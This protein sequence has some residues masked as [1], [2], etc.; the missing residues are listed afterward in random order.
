MIP[1][2]IMFGDSARQ[3]MLRGIQTLTDAVKVTLGPKGR[4]VVINNRNQP[5]RITKD[6]VSVA[7]EVVLKDD[8]E[9]LGARI[10]KEV[11]I[12]TC[13][14]AGDGT[15]T[16]T[17]LAC[18][19]ITKGMA[20]LEDG[21]NPVALKRGIDL[22]V[23]EVVSFLKSI[24]KEI[25]SHEEIVQVATISANGEE[26]IG[27]LIADA[28][29]KV[30]KDGAVTI[31]ET[32]SIKTELEIVNGLQF[33]SGYISPYFV[34]NAAKMICELDNPYILIYENKFSSF[35]QL[36]NI[37]EYVAQNNQSLL[38]ICDEMELDAL[39][40]FVL[41]KVRR[42]YKIAAVKC[43]GMDQGRFDLLQDLSAMTG[44]HI[45][46]SH[47]GIK[48]QNAK[49]E[50]LGKVTK[51]IITHNST[52][53]IGEESDQENLKL[54]IEYL[55]DE[56]TKSDDDQ[57]V[58]Y[59]RA[60]LGSLT[61]GIAVIRV[62]GSTELEMKERKDRVEDA[63]HATRA[64]LQEGIVPGGGI[65]LYKARLIDFLDSRL[66]DEIY[67]GEQIVHRAIQKPILQILENSG[68]K[69]D[70]FIDS[71]LCYNINT[72][73]QIS[74]GY[75]AKNECFVDMFEAGI[76]DPTKVVRTALEDAAS[77]AGLF[78]LTEVAMLEEM[79]IMVGD[80]DSSP[81]TFRIKTA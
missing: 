5:L 64:A 21:A 48:T 38:V 39:Q 9:N 49:P 32:K 31:E 33:H 4:N 51:A 25:T 16:A 29:A 10:L 71:V 63:M 42:G 80:M 20:A 1:K 72:N 65:A 60:R 19:I 45:F 13:S 22:A 76:I 30:T 69:S 66:E 57:M 2:E 17:V 11:A 15:T 79:E 46:S 47:T 44:A 24:S 41:G 18:E 40:T 61:N 23:I 73:N 43:P 34:T 27:K 59:L 37:C 67:A 7:K 6:G 56:I 3:K 35:K 8:F 78:L 55:Q 70:E 53:L 12:K 75:D 54:H 52:T 14:I 74:Y 50:H 26:E 28:F 36:E 77:V 58:R 62:G 68:G 81:Q